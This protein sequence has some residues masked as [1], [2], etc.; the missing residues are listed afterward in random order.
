MS[1]IAAVPVRLDLFYSPYCPH[2][3]KARALLKALI[4][5]FP[6]GSLQLCELDVVEEIDR[7]V[8]LGVMRTPALVVDGV[9]TDGAVMTRRALGKLLRERLAVAR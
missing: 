2:C 9:L 3:G 1:V 6:P 7:A 5:D 4:S 8:A